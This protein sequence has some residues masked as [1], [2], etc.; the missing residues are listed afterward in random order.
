MKKVN[1]VCT[2][3]HILFSTKGIVK[4]NIKMAVFNINFVGVAST[5]DMSGALSTSWIAMLYESFSPKSESVS[6][7]SK[8]FSESLSNS[9]CF[10]PTH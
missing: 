8:S 4:I 6:E 7:S 10:P 9:Y 5:S 2:I 1:W 3:S